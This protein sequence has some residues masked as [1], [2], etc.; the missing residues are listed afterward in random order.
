MVRDPRYGTATNIWQIGLTMQVLMRKPPNRVPDWQHFTTSQSK[1]TYRLATGGLAVGSILDE[2]QDWQVGARSL[3]SR[4]L[5]P[6]IAECLLHTL[7]S[8]GN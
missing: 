8:L 3:Y 1:A 6:L 7:A 5:R 2:E 4:E